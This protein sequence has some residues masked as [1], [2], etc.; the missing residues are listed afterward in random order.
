[1]MEVHLFTIHPSE[2]ELSFVSLFKKKK[3]TQE[4]E[5]QF[6]GKH[7]EKDSSTGGVW[8]AVLVLTWSPVYPIDPWRKYK[9]VV[10]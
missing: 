9:K 10:L 3:K 6:L 8:K 5:Y 7:G 1:M 2:S 4:V